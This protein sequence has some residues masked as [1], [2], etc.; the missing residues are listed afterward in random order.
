MQV[1]DK[2]EEIITIIERTNEETNKQ[3]N[4]WIN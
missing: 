4:E 2:W 1:F 3:M